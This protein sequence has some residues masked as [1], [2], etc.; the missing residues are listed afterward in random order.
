[1]KFY[2]DDRIQSLHDI[3][4]IKEGQIN[5]S[6]ARNTNNVVAWHKHEIQKD[7]WCCIKGSFKV[8]IVDNGKVY[9]KYLSDKDFQALS[10]F[11]G[12]YHGYRALEPNSIM[13]YYLDQKY[14]KNDEFK[15]PPG[16]F[17]EIWE[18]ENK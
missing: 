18:S 1:M 8:G 7:Y 13:L 9:W 10:I 14:D 17:G 4:P 12:Q 15:K 5:I 2:E 3:F 6:I 16:Y 11:P